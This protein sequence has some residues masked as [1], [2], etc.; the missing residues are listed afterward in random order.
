MARGALRER[1]GAAA[2]VPSSPAASGKAAEAEAAAPAPARDAGR[3]QRGAP[4]WAGGLVWAAGASLTFGV[5]SWLRRLERERLEAAEARV[6]PSCSA[7]VA[8]QP[9]A[10]AAIRRR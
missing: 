1:V 3:R 4:G 5:Q 7:C 6:R 8:W 2:A 9:H 10:A